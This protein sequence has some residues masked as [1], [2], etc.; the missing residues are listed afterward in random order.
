MQVIEFAHRLDAKIGFQLPCPLFNNGPV[1][2]F[3]FGTKTVA[4]N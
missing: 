4:V 2:Q 3:A 1:A